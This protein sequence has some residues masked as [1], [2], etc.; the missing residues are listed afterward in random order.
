MANLP[1]DHPVLHQHFVGWIHVA[2]R[3][4][5]AWAGLS[6]DLMVER[7]LMRSMKTSGGLTRGR[8]M[9]V[10]QRL[11]WLLAMP[12]CAEVNRA[13]QEMSGAK[14]STNEQNKETG[15]SRQRRDMKYTH[16]LLLTMSERNPFAESTSLRNI[17]TGVNVTGDVDVCRAKE[18]GKKIMD[19]MTGI[20]VAQYTFKRSD[21]RW[22]HF[23]RSLQCALMDS[24]YTSTQS[25]CY[26]TSLSHPMVLRTERRYS[27]SSCV[28]THRLSLTT[29]SCRE[30]HRKPFCRTLSG[31]VCH[32]TLPDQLARFNMCWT[33]GHCSIV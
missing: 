32:Q 27:V 12:A 25:S 3:S 24:R 17:V 6:T 10:Q 19:S 5:R 30:H 26:N 16:A 9:T 2:R 20:P 8:G 11:T 18:I 14:Y 31:P 22:R 33:M 23:S 4:D 28:A 15:K 29:H 1:N 21:H 13:M 7:V